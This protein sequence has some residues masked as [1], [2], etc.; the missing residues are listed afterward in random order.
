MAQHSTARHGTARHGMGP[1]STA[2][3]STARHGR[4]WQSLARHSLVCHGTAWDSLAHHGTV[5]G[6]SS[7][8]GATWGQAKR[9]DTVLIPATARGQASSPGAGVSKMPGA[10]RDPSPAVRQGGR[11]VVLPWHCRHRPFLGAGT[12]PQ[13][14]QPVL[15]LSPSLSCPCPQAGGD[16]RGAEQGSARAV[17]GQ[18]QAVGTALPRPLVQCE[19]NQGGWRG[20][21]GHILR[22]WHGAGGGKCVSA[23]RDGPIACGH[24]DER[25]GCRQS[26]GRVQ[27]GCRQERCRQGLQAGEEQ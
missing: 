22:C 6:G 8:P 16:R 26:A 14:R 5:P 18:C 21:V 23:P 17:P 13:P 10:G 12:R 20:R 3:H 11:L 1:H 4:A 7:M 27:A 15:S 24:G 9:R 25:A 19:M 2:L